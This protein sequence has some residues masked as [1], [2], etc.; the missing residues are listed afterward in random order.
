LEA[1]IRD[2][3]TNPTPYYYLGII[4]QEQ[5]N[6]DKAKDYLGDGGIVESGNRAILLRPGSVANQLAETSRSARDTGPRRAKFRQS[7]A[8]ELYSGIA[9]SA[10]RKYDDALGYYT[11][12]EVSPGQPSQKARLRFLFPSR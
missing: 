8:M 6:T 2:K 7:F 12:A 5:K 11:A 3:P 4:A 10:L 9:S 1:L